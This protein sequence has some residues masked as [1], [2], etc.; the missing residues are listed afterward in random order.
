MRLFRLLAVFA[1]TITFLT[2]CTRPQEFADSH[3]DVVRPVNQVAMPPMTT[4]SIIDRNGLSETISV[5]DR[6]K[7]YQNVNFLASQPYQKVLRVFARNECGDIAAIVTTYHPNGQ[8]KQY[9]DIV[10]NRAFGYYREWHANGVLKLQTEIING[11]PDIAPGTEKTWLFEGVSKVWNECGRLEA[12]I[13]YCRGELEGI[14]IYYH[15]NGNIWKK[16]PY[17]AGKLHGTVTVYMETGTVLS[18]T[19][20]IQGVKCGSAFRYWNADQY[21]AEEQ[22][23]N[24]LLMEAQYWNLNGETAAEIHNG[25]GFRAIFGKETLSELQQYNQGKQ[26]GQV[27]VLAK[28]GRLL[29]LYH[30]KNGLKNGEETEYRLTAPIDMPKV[31]ITWSNGIIQG[32]VRTWYDNGRM[33]SQRDMSENVKNGMLSAWYRDGS[34]MMIEEY[35]H[36]KLVKG[37]YFGKGDKFPISTV[38]SGKGYATIFDPEGVFIRKIVYHR[39][40]PVE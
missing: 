35:D 40:K 27:K 4:I 18:E 28:N 13:P 37:K 20:Y 7:Q 1:C 30:V 11:N 19:E 21:A 8:I 6:I 22:Y 3:P 36:D 10:N 2:G 15:P 38:S 12:E 39:G 26:E 17:K 23:V 33:E 14:S 29:R 5:P 32:P 34:V 9:L 31:M 16:E 24:G 25:N